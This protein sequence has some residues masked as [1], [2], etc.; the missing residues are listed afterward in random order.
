MLKPKKIAVLFSIVSITLMAMVRERSS[1]GAPASHT[2]APGEKTCATAGCHDDNTINSGTAS[3]NIDMGATTQYTPGKTYPVKIRITDPGVNRFGFQIVALKNTDNSNIGIFELVDKKQTQMVHNKYEL[4]DRQYI[5]YTFEGT[6][7]IYD[8]TGEWVVNWIAPTA[9]VG[10]VTFYAAAVSGND[11]GI[12]K[13][14][15]VYTSVKT[16][17]N[18]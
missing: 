8:G 18:Q 11:D 2:G 15:H 4:S 1:S 12:D 5:T 10:A 7:A 14:D 6:D 16:I 3:L 17:T 13:G 9:D